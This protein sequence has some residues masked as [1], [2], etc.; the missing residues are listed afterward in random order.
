MR[1]FLLSSQLQALINSGD[2]I[3]RLILV[4]CLALI[5][6]AC[7]KE[8]HGIYVSDA[9]ANSIEVFALDANGNAGPLDLP[10]SGP[11]T[12]LFEPCGVFVDGSGVIWASNFKGDTITRYL[13]PSK[14]D[15]KPYAIAGLLTQ[16]NGPTGLTLSPTADIYSA[17]TGGDAILIFAPDSKGNV[18]P[19]TTISG[20]STML[21]GPKGLTLDSAGEIIVGDQNDGAVNVFSATASGDVAPS[22]RI[23]GVHTRLDGDSRGVAVDAANQIYVAEDGALTDTPMAILVFASGAKGDVS[24]VQRISGAK[25]Q[26]TEPFGITVDTKYIYVSDDSAINVYSKT[27][28]GN[29]GPIR[30]I[31]GPATLLNAPCGIALH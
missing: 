13:P 20:P 26:L 25:T 29:V 21:L 30:R 8:K 16:L 12:K 23:I 27:A 2:R 14:G 7:G 19:T 3:V 15:A 18:K 6:T 9:L 17:Q 24:P 4:A 10:I 1:H 5:I 11:N 22:R 31:V 28:T